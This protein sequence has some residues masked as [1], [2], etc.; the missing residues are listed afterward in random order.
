MFWEQEQE[1]IPTPSPSIEEAQKARIAPKRGRGQAVETQEAVD[2]EGEVVSSPSKRK[3]ERER[4]KPSSSS[5][6]RA[7]LA[8]SRISK[9]TIIMLIN[10]I[11]DKIPK[12]IINEYGELIGRDANKNAMVSFYKSHI[13]NK[14]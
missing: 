2:N 11:R 14:F 4:N 13:Y 5:N 9:G 12:D 10:E 7:T 1:T 8:P 6:I 3:Q